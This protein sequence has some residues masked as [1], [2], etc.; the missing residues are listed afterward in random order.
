MTKE[1]TELPPGFFHLGRG[2]EE[3]NIVHVSHV[4]AISYSDE[5]G[6]FVALNSAF[7]LLTSL[8][9]LT[10]LDRYQEALISL[11]DFNNSLE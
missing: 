11:R 7:S 8:P 5:K 6:V 9:L 4:S 10:V 1:E 3:Y 2:V